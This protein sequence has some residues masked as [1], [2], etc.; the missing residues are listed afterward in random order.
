MLVIALSGDQIERAHAAFAAHGYADP[1]RV[2]PVTSDDE[3]VFIISPDAAVIN[4]EALAR[5]LQDILHRKVW[6]VASS[7]EWS[8]S[9]PLS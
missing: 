2:A 1:L 9:E 7:P 3:R 6:I 4:H 8:E 5:D